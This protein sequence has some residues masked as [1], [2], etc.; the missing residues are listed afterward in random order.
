TI[1]RPRPST[2][3][4]KAPRANPSAPS[5]T[6]TRPWSSSPGSTSNCGP[7][8][9]PFLFR[10]DRSGHGEF[11][12]LALPEMAT[13]YGLPLPGERH[14]RPGDIRL[15]EAL[16]VHALA[17]SHRSTAVFLLAFPRLGGCARTHG[18]YRGLRTIR[19]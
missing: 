9:G 13:L 16:P 12:V 8:P 10:R 19:P 2:S 7:C 4:A 18:L 14:S 3:R 15:H 1:P 5:C 6:S 11:R 17:V